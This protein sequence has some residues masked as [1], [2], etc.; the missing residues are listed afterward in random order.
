MKSMF[1]YLL[2]PRAWIA[3]FLLFL[4]ASGFVALA[5]FNYLT[6]LQTFLDSEIFSFNVGTFRVSAW[7]M[8]KF[9][10][11]FIIFFW[12]AGIISEFGEKR[13]HKLRQ[14]SLRSRALFTKAY[15]ILIYFIAF[16]IA[17]DLLGLDLTGLTIFSGAIGLGIGIGLQ[18]IS[19]NF[20]SGLI[21][22]FERAVEEGDMIELSDGTTGIV[23]R[24]NARFTLLET[25]ESREILIPNE[26]F[27]TDRVT[28][29][30]YS[31]QLGRVDIHIGVAYG[32]NLKMTKTI[33]LE[34]ARQHPR[35][36]SVPEPSCY[37]TNFGDN[38]VEFTL[39]FFVD[40]ITEGRY[41]PKSDVLFEIA[42]QF[43]KYNI[44]IP[45]PQRDVTIKNGGGLPGQMA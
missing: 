2:K 30:T 4:M 15:Q 12:L 37:L 36:V 44:T 7:L 24:T 25:F 26:D 31:N 42:E 17:L 39:F 18:K 6:P 20:I 3:K 23:R 45:F 21:M 28:N 43:E 10:V 33:L 1:L 8:A 5:Y 41:G 16:L 38:A 40:S 13:I 35:C 9:V 14:V 29:W 22:L 27:I 11:A 32:T 34:A 19:S